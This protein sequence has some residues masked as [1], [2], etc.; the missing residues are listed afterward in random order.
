MVI[1]FKSSF[2]DKCCFFLMGHWIEHYHAA[3]SKLFFLI[4]IHLTEYAEYLTN[5]HCTLFLGLS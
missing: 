3:T 2:P 4:E 5:L 1:K